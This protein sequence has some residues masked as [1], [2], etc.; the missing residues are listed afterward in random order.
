[1]REC[2]ASLEDNGDMPAPSKYTESI[3]TTTRERS[4]SLKANGVFNFRPHSFL[5]IE[6]A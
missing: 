1:M 6:K 4:A 2:S 5:I 3:K